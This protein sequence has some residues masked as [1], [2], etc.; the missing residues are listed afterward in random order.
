MA[1][2]HL[3]S[4]S[5][6]R[7]LCFFAVIIPYATSSLFPLNKR[8]DFKVLSPQFGDTIGPLADVNI[9]WVNTTDRNVTI[10]LKKGFLQN[11]SQILLLTTTA[12]NNGSWQ[13][14]AHDIDGGLYYD[15]LPP[16]CDY[17][18]E[19]STG[20]NVAISDYFNI[21]TKNRGVPTN[22]SCPT[23]TGGWVRLAN[24]Q[25]QAAGKPAGSTG[26]GGTGVSA[27]ALG[28]V[29]GGVVAGLLALFAAMVVMGRQRGWF[30]SE[31]FLAD[32]MARHPP[33]PPQTHS[34]EMYRPH[35]DGEKDYGYHNV[36]Q[37]PADEV[38]R[39]S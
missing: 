12:P 29:V 20:G 38:H 4:F 30:V 31:R 6:M 9:S 22:A 15:P 19:L 8:A 7:F 33:P 26:G 5:I 21:I 35:E 2:L 28:G 14:R 34:A 1:R 23:S 11:L 10:G 32:Y 24:G 16:G 18:M 36:A 13:W 39:I 17:V 25:S 27:A 3:S 37:L